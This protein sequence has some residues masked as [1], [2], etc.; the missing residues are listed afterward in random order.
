M[1]SPTRCNRCGDM[2]AIRRPLC[3]D[4]RTTVVNNGNMLWIPE[5]ER[6]EVLR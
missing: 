1:Q 2:L 3:V 5:R 6:E 4:C